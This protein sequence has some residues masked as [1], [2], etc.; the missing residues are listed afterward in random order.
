V[1]VGNSQQLGSITS[2]L[3]TL[4]KGVTTAAKTV[5]NPINSLGQQA[6]DAALKYKEIKA[7]LNPPV[8]TAYATPG[9]T[10]ERFQPGTTTLISPETPLNK[11]EILA[12]QTALA[13][14]GIDPGPLDGV[15]G[16]KTAAAISAWQQRNYV[17]IDGKLSR[18]LYY[19]VTAASAPPMGVPVAPIDSRAPSGTP[20]YISQPAPQPSAGFQLPSFPQ[21]AIPAGLLLI[22][23]AVILSRRK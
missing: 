19:M 12:L 9:Y 17:A 20:I 18:S 16:P 6:L 22:G 4:T 1:Y 13:R 15:Y 23:G 3:N 10:G 5:T 7:V 14:Q 2:F 21:W 8:T 11:S